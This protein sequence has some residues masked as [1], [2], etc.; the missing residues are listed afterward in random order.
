MQEVTSIFTVSITT[1]NNASEAGVERLLENLKNKKHIRAFEN[2]L[3][4]AICA[5]DVK[6]ENIQHFVM[7]K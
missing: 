2:E 4:D 5:D 7:D 1:I 6:I 3:K